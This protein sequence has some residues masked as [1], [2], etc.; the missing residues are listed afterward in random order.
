[1]HDSLP[2]CFL[3]CNADD[4]PHPHVAEKVNA[5][6][7][8][9]ET[10]RFERRPLLQ[11]S[12]H[13]LAQRRAA[14]CSPCIRH[15]IS[16]SVAEFP[17]WQTRARTARG[18]CAC[19][20]TARQARVLSNGFRDGERRRPTA[21]ASPSPARRGAR[22][23]S[24]RSSRRRTCRRAAPRGRPPTLRRCCPS[25]ALAGHVQHGLTGRGDDE[26][27]ARALQ[28]CDARA[29]RAGHWSRRARSRANDAAW[30][31]R[32][33]SP[34]QPLTPRRPPRQPRRPPHERR[35]RSGTTF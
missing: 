25:A 7:G 4:I 31:P 15:R 3:T 30:P 22:G 21:R 11:A 19:D 18:L 24:T 10:T 9:R 26:L 16:T 35:G 2:R 6:C 17:V 34:P 12:T 20:R 29:G 13:R 27:A 14:T 32:S 33:R 5:T 23:P 8:P 28:G 1:M